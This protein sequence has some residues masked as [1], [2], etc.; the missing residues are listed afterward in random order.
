MN[1]H[2][3]ICQWM[4]GNEKTVKVSFHSLFEAINTV[5]GVSPEEIKAKSMQERPLEAR[6]AFMFIAKEYL[7]YNIYEIGKELGR[8]RT[9]VSS[10]VKSFRNRMHTDYRGVLDK[11]NRILFILDINETIGTKYKKQ[12]QTTDD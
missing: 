5:L 10:G 6:H 8:E 9:V 3:A 12:N 7:E 4:S 1:M 2:V 11:L